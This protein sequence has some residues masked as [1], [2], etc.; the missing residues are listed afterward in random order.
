MILLI[1]K[2][3]FAWISKEAYLSTLEMA[4]GYYAQ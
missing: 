3:C 2:R 4:G 1:E